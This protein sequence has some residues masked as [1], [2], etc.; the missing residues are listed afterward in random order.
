MVPPQR[1][2]PIAV[3]PIYPTL[4]HE[5]FEEVWN[6]RNTQ[7]IDRLLAPEAVVHGIVDESGR[8]L[9]GPHA[10]RAKLKSFLRGARR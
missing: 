2:Q 9:V 3:M 7:T 1:N 6:Q 4:V 8:E 10:F 5:W